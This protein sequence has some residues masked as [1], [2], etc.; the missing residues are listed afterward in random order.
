MS[1]KKRNQ[2]II[3]VIL[4]VI[5]LL[6]GLLNLLI[7]RDA[8][9][10]YLALEVYFF[11]YVFFLSGYFIGMNEKGFGI[12]FLFSH[13]VIGLLIMCFSFLQDSFSVPLLSDLPRNAGNY[14]CATLS[15]F[16]VATI[17]VIAYNISDRVKQTKY[18]VYIPLIL[19]I[20]GF[21]MV[22]LFRIKIGY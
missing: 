20:I 6:E 2:K 19:Y 7:K 15:F 11:G 5:V 8:G 18:S 4:S 3:L 14:L 17:N 1:E 22:G 16:V 10:N 12:I 13:G 9:S 21:A